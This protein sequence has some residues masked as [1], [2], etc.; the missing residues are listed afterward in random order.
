MIFQTSRELCSS[1]YSS[2]VYHSHRCIGHGSC[3]KPK[4]RKIQHL[5]KF[6]TFLNH[7]G[8]IGH[9]QKVHR[10]VLVRDSG[11]PRVAFPWVAFPKTLDILTFHELHPRKLTWIPKMMGRLEK[12]LPFNMPIVGIYFRFRGCMEYWLVHGLGFEIHAWLTS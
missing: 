7:L 12:E 11:W 5:K 1:R 9:G 4:Y 3:C 6:E 8:L 2:G 10:S